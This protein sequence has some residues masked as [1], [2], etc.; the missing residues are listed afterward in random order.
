M[1]F[2]VVSNSIVE[3]KSSKGQN[4]KILRS[5]ILIF[6]L[7]GD[8]D[9]IKDEN[10]ESEKYLAKIRLELAEINQQIAAQQRILDNVPAQTEVS[11][12]QRRIIELY[13]QSLWFDLILI[14]VEQ[15]GHFSLQ[16]FSIQL[17]KV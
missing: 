13:N 7:K 17:Q 2:V 10:L 16:E 8:D 11:Q 9:L 6:P 5:P 3:L 14:S 1:F 4:V 12:Y 15:S